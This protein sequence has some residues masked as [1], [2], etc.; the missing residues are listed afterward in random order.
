[1]LLFVF[2]RVEWKIDDFLLCISEVQ[3]FPRWIFYGSFP[4]INISF[5]L[6]IS[7]QLIP[8]LFSAIQTFSAFLYAFV[9]QISCLR[10]C[11]LFF[12]WNWC[13]LDLSFQDEQSSQMRVSI[14]KNISLL[15]SYYPIHIR[16]HLVRCLDAV[17]YTNFSFLSSFLDYIFSTTDLILYHGKDKNPEN[18]FLIKNKNCLIMS[19]SWVFLICSP[20]QKYWE[21]K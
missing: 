20:M 11:F 10:I 1:M 7:R 15:R 6:M 8:S 5:L 19:R 14:D 9:E 4:F 2:G 18:F 13:D 17:S 16:Q 21:M 12:L 3:F